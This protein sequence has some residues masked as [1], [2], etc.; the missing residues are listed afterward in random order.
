MQTIF[1][2]NCF[3]PVTH[4]KG[5]V[6][7]QTSAATIFPHHYHEG[8]PSHLVCDGWCVCEQVIKKCTSTPW[9]L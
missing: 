2:R 3:K 6:S 1:T 8:L 7:Y 5:K 4:L 9:N